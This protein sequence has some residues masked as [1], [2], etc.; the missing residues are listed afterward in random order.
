MTEKT[1]DYIPETNAE[2]QARQIDELRKRAYA[3]PDNGSDRLFAEAQRMKIMSDG[4][5]QAK[6]Q[7]AIA[8][9][10]E[11]KASYPWPVI[12]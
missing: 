7:E 4:N 10:E 11:I 8:R 1:S 6:E 12:S 5:W 3:N 2:Y 9:Y